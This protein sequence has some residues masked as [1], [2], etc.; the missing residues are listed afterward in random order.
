M[1]MLCLN[2]RNQCKKHQ[3]CKLI[4]FIVKKS[5]FNLILFKKYRNGT[6]FEEHTI[7][8]DSLEND[9]H[10]DHSKS[11]F[12][13]NLSFKTTEDEVNKNFSRKNFQKY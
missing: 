11:L 9:R 7:Q 8:V 4:V 2:N 1:H 10:Y 3:N 6:K 12:L 5:K 13:G